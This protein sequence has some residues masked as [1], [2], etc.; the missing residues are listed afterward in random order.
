MIPMKILALVLAGGT[1]TRLYP[2]TAEHSKPALPFANG[3]RIIDFV[4]SNLV[5]SGIGAIYVLAQ[6][7]PQ[8]LIRHVESTWMP[9]LTRRKGFVRV[10]LPRP[11]SGSGY[12]RGTADAVYHNLDVIW[13]HG[14]DLVAIFAADHV[15]RMD[16]GQMV[17]F[18]K[19]RKADVTVSAIRVPIH[20]AGAFAVLPTRPDGEVRHF[21]GKPGA[22][23]SIPDDPTRAFVSMGN[24]LFDP[25]VLVDAL[26]AGPRRSTTDFGRDILP[27]LPGRH[28]IYAYDFGRNYVPGVQSYEQ[29]AYW[30]DVTSL[31]ALKAAQSDVRGP[32]PLFDL[33]NAQ[34]PLYGASQSAPQPAADRSAHS[35]VPGAPEIR[36]GA[37]RLEQH[38]TVW[39]LPPAVPSA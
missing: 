14:P 24:Y 34:W 8:S 22:L 19:A 28:R 17:C 36:R 20:R 31:D 21:Q 5:N 30:R 29:R 26:E 4:L 6:Y 3:Y 15:Y 33:S 11:D 12:Y 18:H 9:A 1:G 35:G 7:K 2:L 23:A 16:V 10:Q 27:R 25:N 39:R 38:T 32:E 37:G 13:R